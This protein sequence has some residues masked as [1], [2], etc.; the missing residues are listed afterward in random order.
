MRPVELMIQAFGPYAERETI[1]FT[2][3][4]GRSMFVVSGRTGAGK[5]TI[6]DA[7]T[8]ALYGRA[9]GSLRNASDF[10]SQYAQPEL[11]TEVDFSFTIRGDRY[12]IVRQPQ[13]PHPKN[14]TPIPHEAILYEWEDGW[15]PLATKVNEIQERIESILQLSY[16]QFS[17]ILLLP[18]NQFRQLLDSNSN[19]KQQILQSIFKTEAYRTFQ[20]KWGERYSA[21]RKQVEWAVER[22]RL[23]LLE[24]EDEAIEEVSTQSIEEIQRWLDEREEYLM[25]TCDTAKTQKQLYATAL[26]EAREALEKA[27]SLVTLFKEREETDRALAI[28]LNGESIRNETRELLTNLEVAANIRPVF[29]RLQELEQLVRRL[30]IEQQTSSTKLE[31]L[32]STQS[33]LVER[34][35]TIETDKEEVISRKERLR[36]VDEMMPRIKERATLV[37]L[38]DRLMNRAKE[39]AMFSKESRL[40]ELQERERRLVDSI[41]SEPS[42]RAV[43]AERHVDRLVHLASLE[44]KARELSKQLDECERTGKDV[45][46]QYVTQQEVVTTFTQQ[47]QL[48]LAKQLSETLVDGEPC[49]VCGSR[50]HDIPQ[51]EETVTNIAERDA[52]VARLDDLSTRLIEARADYRSLHQQ[53]EAVRQ[54]LDQASKDIQFNGDVTEELNKWRTRAELLQREERM[55]QENER[56]LRQLSAEI[57]QLEQ[58]QRQQFEER[59]RVVSEL[60][61]TQQSLYALGQSEETTFDALQRERA[62]LEH[63]ISMLMKQVEAYDLEFETV[64]K[65]LWKEEERLSLIREQLTEASKQYDAQ[66]TIW[67][68]QLEASHLTRER[69][70]SYANQIDKR[71]MIREQLQREEEEGVRL[72]HHKQMIEEKLKN[73]ERPDLHEMEMKVKEVAE[74]SE[75][76]SKQLITAQD[77]LSRHRHVI[78]E[79]NTLREQTA[80]EEQ[81]LETIKLI[82]DTGK[83]INPQKMTFETYVQTAFFDQILHAA[84]IHL[85]QMTSGQFRLERKVETA[86]GNAKSGLELLVF[87]AYTGQSRRVQNLSGGEGFKAS[88]SLAL[89]LAEVVQQLSGGISLETM[90]IDEG[91]GTLDA[92]SLDQ[93]IELLMSLQATGRLVG[94][95]SHVQELKDRVDARIE[96]KKSRSGS[97][98]QLIVE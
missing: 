8:F 85:D 32:Q 98:I 89:G 47:E 64:K 5:T 57:R 79:W 1:D 49:P 90:L 58:E 48:I 9:S 73:Q 29:E 56:T 17:Q 87:D 27:K 6:F 81:K 23:K 88:L 51:H 19:E 42:E 18:Q 61:M 26:E 68:N 38:R 96:V 16:E 78:S 39:L 84:N 80:Q 41:K 53:L 43:D 40:Q 69:Y 31:H 20:E 3:L 91:F 52:A 30:S 7:M 83:G 28:F 72:R 24:L 67:V 66:Q 15:K 22:T 45:Q 97:S 70:E 77:A 14:K 4:V 59:E 62:D 2:Q 76:A 55:H 10:R 86:K 13:Q 75:Q 34:Q 74:C 60:E 25:T 50:H 36:I 93:A 94:V 71:T 65:A 37:T 44:T 54:E 21:Y 82:A 11:K 33:K 35:P 12:R 95:I 92:E 63:R 46:R